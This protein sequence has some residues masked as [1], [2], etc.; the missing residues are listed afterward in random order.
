MAL[1][2]SSVRSRSAPPIHKFKDHELG[3]LRHFPFHSSFFSL[4]MFISCG[5]PL[6]KTKLE[7]YW[8][9][10]TQK[11]KLIFRNPQMDYN[12]SLQSPRKPNKRVS[13]LPRMER[14]LIKETLKW[15]TRRRMDHFLSGWQT[16]MARKQAK[17]IKS[18]FFHHGTKMDEFA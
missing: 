12:S 14:Y 13:D 9:P 18:W 7:L 5:E 2:R 4:V 8:N 6:L 1:W 15:E 10:K 16:P 11:M 3:T 17:R